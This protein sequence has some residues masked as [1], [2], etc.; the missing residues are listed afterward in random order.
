VFEPQE[1]SSTRDRHQPVVLCVDDHELGLKMR[2]LLL[3]M[4]GYSVLTALTACEGLR[5]F[6]QADVDLVIT[7]YYLPDQLGSEL[8]ETMKLLR[9]GVPILL[10]SGSVYEP[11]DM[12]GANAFLSK[13]TQPEHFLALVGEMLRNKKVAGYA[14]N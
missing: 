9:P 11:E 2:E 4:E 8:A 10:L 7:D 5:A 14:L 6:E 13:A 1:E 12:G 3:K